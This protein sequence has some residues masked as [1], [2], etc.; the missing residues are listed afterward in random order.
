MA[1]GGALGVAGAAS[2]VPGTAHAT[3][4]RPQ[5]IARRR[6]T[7]SRSRRNSTVAVSGSPHPLAPLNE[8]EIEQAFGV[9]EADSRFI[10]E[11]VFPILELKE[12]PK[13]FVLGW[14]APAPFMREALA[15]VYHPPSNKFFEI[16]VDLVAGSIASWN[17]V[18]GRQP[19]VYASEYELQA[20][21]IEEDPEWQAAM[22]RRGIDPA[23][24]YLDG[25]AFGDVRVQG[26]DSTTQRYTR[27]LSFYRGSLP[28]P[29]DRPIEGVVV[30]VNMNTEEVVKVI[31]TGVRPVD[32]TT[33]G[34][35][36]T[37]RPPLKPLVTSQPQGP[38]FE[39]DGMAVSWQNWRFRLGFSWRDG[40]LLHQIGFQEEGKEL[41]PIIYR[42]SLNE[43]F[44]P[45]ALPDSNWSWR[46]AFDI[47][48]YNLAQYAEP[49]QGGID[50]P[51]N[52][53][54]FD[55]VGPSDQGAA[56]GVVTLSNALALYE[57]NSGV[58]WDRTDPSS[59]VRDARGGRELVAT[60]AYVNGNYTYAVEYVF[61]MDGG[62]GCYVTANG[63][64]LNRGI[65]D[66]EEQAQFQTVLNRNI[67]APVHQHF[68]NYRID[69]D[70]DG[71]DNTV[72][73]TN[74]KATASAQ[75]NAFV[76]E[77]TPLTREQHRDLEDKTYRRWT[78][79]SASRRNAQ[80]APTG[81]ELVPGDSTLA[82]AS[83]RYQPLRRAAFAQHPF[84]VTRYADGEHYASGAYPNQGPVGEGLAAYAAGREDT[85]GQDLVVWFTT[86]FTHLPAVENYPVMAAET[87]GF[88]LE[89][90]GFFDRDPTLDVS[91]PS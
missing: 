86:A 89:P 63:T 74:L 75:G 15:H 90:A 17:E 45:Y 76:K 57:R 44:V 87:I 14:Q 3:S 12:P 70:I 21:I 46:A 35:S 51:E 84:W 65:N 91:P 79:R 23:D 88:K 83:S 10:P 16:V 28:N 6:R 71:T 5:A 62:I 55:L 27:A 42:L 53:V 11:S 34:S 24:V 64:T 7:V 13:A 36:S 49:L 60:M 30:I 61:G 19:A 33:S 39:L 80:G 43:I 69:F 38:D 37:T 68:F 40:L 26:I 9:I 31:D 66:G 52:A 77:E 25:W 29:Y 20:E 4:A 56:G 50:V 32:T 1:L 67:A 58:L 85:V 48:E 41:R 8:A 18:A 72:F 54:F 81:Y 59:Y 73:E 82:Y 22:R 47:G 78:V 2:L